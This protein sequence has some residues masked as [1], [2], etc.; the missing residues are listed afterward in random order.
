MT[1][2]NEALI[3]MITIAYAALMLLTAQLFIEHRSR[4]DATSLAWSALPSQV[5]AS[6]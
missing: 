3:A 2:L 5:P 6:R 4:N 1:T